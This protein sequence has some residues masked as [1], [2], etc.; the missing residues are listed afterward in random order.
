MKNIWRAIL[1]GATLGVM[2]FVLTHD[3]FTYTNLLSASLIF[4]QSLVI[5]WLFRKCDELEAEEDD[6]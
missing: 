4:I 5:I 3:P 2:V 1:N 6:F